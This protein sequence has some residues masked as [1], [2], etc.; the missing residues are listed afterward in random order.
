MQLD[1]TSANLA[2]AKPCDAGRPAR[3]FL[4]PARAF[5]QRGAA[6]ET[7]GATSFSRGSTP[8]WDLAAP[9]ARQASTFD[10]ARQA[11]QAFQGR[12]LVNARSGMVVRVS[13]N[14][15]DKMLSAKAVGKSETAAAHAAAVANLDKLFEG[16]VLGWSKPDREGNTNIRAVHRFFGPLNIDGTVLLA[17]LTVKET[18]DPTH[19]NPL[20]TVE[21]IELNEKSPAA[22]WVDATVKADG[23]DPTSI[24]SAGD[25]RTLAEQVQ[26]FNASPRAAFS[27]SPLAAAVTNFSQA[28]ARN[29]FLDAVSFVAAWETAEA[30]GIANPFAFAEKAVVETQGLYNKGNKANF[31]R[32][33]FGA[34]V[35]TFK[36]FSTHYLEFLVRMWKSG[37][38][39][40]R[41]VAVAL[42]L[43][44]LMGGAG[45]LPFADDL[46]D[47]IDTLG[48]ATWASGSTT[49]AGSACTSGWPSPCSKSSVAQTKS[50]PSV[51]A[52]WKSCASGRG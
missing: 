5:V 27:R 28:G 14:S 7:A 24:R 46:D 44:V 45:G 18:V 1:S 11:A 22:Q 8:A 2:G 21:A 47:L 34:T 51:G 15:L 42:A 4:L 48:Q 30:E 3:R 17:K 25:V 6:G 33:A 26:A 41:A 38:E 9:A 52:L 37:P 29:A 50:E 39:G 10:E 19:A 20:Y 12:D 40:K 36:Q 31:A 23:L 35:M 16:A 49:R 43:L 13:R 32:G